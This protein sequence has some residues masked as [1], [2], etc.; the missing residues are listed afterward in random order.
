M[1][2]VTLSIE[3]GTFSPGFAAETAR[4]LG[5]RLADFGRVEKDLAER[6][7]RDGELP[8]IVA[9]SS[10]GARCWPVSRCAL[11]TRLREEVLETAAAGDVLVVGWLAP[12]ILRSFEHVCRIAIRAP[13]EHRAGI[14]QR[15]LRYSRLEVAA[16]E[17]EFDDTLIAQFGLCLLGEDCRDVDSYDLVLNAARLT[18]DQCQRQIRGVVEAAQF[19]ESDSTRAALAAA[20]EQLSLLSADE[21]EVRSASDCT[22]P[23]P[24]TA[25]DHE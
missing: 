9:R 25:R 16:L 1:A 6:C 13:H 17:V 20:L 24:L 7:T 21:A 19:Q 10:T 4:A 11:A 2:I 5:L 8:S 12:T 14:V 18:Q 23:N 3:S 15:S 22:A